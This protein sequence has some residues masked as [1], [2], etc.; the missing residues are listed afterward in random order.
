MD[1]K[2]ACEQGNLELV[3]CLISKN[4]YE[5]NEWDSGFYHACINGHVPIAELM[6]SKKENHNYNWE[7]AFQLACSN[8]QMNIAKLLILHGATNFNAGLWTAHLSGNN[9]DIHFFISKGATNIHN[10]YTWPA[11]YDK[12]YQLLYLGTPLE[13]LSRIN[14]FSDL[15][16]YV[17]NTRQSILKSN[18]MLPDLLSLVANCIII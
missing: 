14:G 8:G 6:I 4:N 18:V 1:L 7:Y 12:I 10:Y 3:T 5:P 16:L 9:M 11:W 13:A 15:K 2:E 17:L